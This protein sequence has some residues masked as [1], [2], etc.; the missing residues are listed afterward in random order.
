[1]R[2]GTALKDLVWL[3]PVALAAYFL[4]SFMGMTEPDNGNSIRYRDN[5]Q[6]TRFDQIEEVRGNL[7]DC[8]RY[9]NPSHVRA[10]NEKHQ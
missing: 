2:L 3:A 5:D 6:S 8:E 1:M 9:A 10:C 4:Y 7:D